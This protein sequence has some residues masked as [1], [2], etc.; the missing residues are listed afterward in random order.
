LYKL[1][2]FAKLTSK[3]G[4]TKV[5]AGRKIIYGKY[6]QIVYRKTT[7]TNKSRLGLAIAKKHHKLAVKRNRLKRIA[8]EFFRT[9]LINGFDIIVLSRS[10]KEFDNSK[11]FNDLQILF[12]KLSKK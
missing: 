10:F 4:Y 11:L 8:R 6:F 1:N 12:D 5:F 2:K 9:N 3:D 7:A